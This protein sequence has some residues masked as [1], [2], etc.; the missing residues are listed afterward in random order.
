MANLAENRKARFDY[1]ILNTLE[2]GLVLTGQEVKAA[3]QGKMQLPGSFIT[4]RRGEAWLVGAV[5]PP[6]Q[7]ANAPAEYDPQRPRKLL[8]RKE[9][10]R[11]LQEI[12]KAQGLTLIP[13]KVYTLKGKIK[14]EVGTGR[15]KKKH[16]KRETLKRKE[17]ERE[18]R[19]RLKY[20]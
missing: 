10:L 5:I 11:G 14:L 7:P 20:R 13:L 2:A 18:M 12:P 8:L 16:D 19:S 6:Y 9:E 15:G 4:L 3:K 17:A 1:E